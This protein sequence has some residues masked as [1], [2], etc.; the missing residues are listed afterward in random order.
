[1]AC[2]LLLSLGS[3][4]P[5]ARAKPAVASVTSSA[6]QLV[7]VSP[8]KGSMLVAAWQARAANANTLQ[9]VPDGKTGTK[10]KVLA[11]SGA[12]RIRRA[13]RKQQYERFQ[14]CAA[15]VA[16]AGDAG[17]AK[18]FATV[19]GCASTLCLVEVDED[20]WSVKSLCVSPDARELPSVA[21]A[22]E[23]A[24]Q[25]LRGLCAGSGG[26]LRV[27][28]E[29][30]ASLVGSRQSLGLTATS[31]DGEL[32]E[33]GGRMGAAEAV[34]DAL[35]SRRTINDF[36]PQLPAGWEEALERAVEAATFA[37][38]HKRTEP[39]RFHLLGPRSIRRVCELNAELVTASKGD[40][41]G[42]KK[43]ERWLA[44]P[45]WLVVT[46]VRREGGDSME[47]PAGLA[48]EDYAAVCCATQNLCLSLHADGLG[49]KWTS[50]PVNFD[51][52]FAGAVGLPDDEYV[53][54]TVWFGAA[55]GEKAPPA[56]AKRLA[57]GDVLRQSD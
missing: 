57:V 10:L 55:A 38:N 36:S 18:L 14:A 28:S 4:T 30:E 52:R 13:N 16:G 43:L 54:G 29:V 8:A 1:M 25:G 56:P 53:V 39:W 12:E 23:A 19:G 48:R 47:E 15:A 44:I 42:A 22:E 5:S 51:P 11:V 49:T 37:P 27:A 2:A 9:T 7:E 26:R 35:R 34:H 20:E 3:L 40:A 21:E 6:P 50:G 33:G 24:L 41:A 31:E 46:C 45:G 17:A 32:G